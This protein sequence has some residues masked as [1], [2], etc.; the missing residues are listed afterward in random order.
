MIRD[1]HDD[2][3][4]FFECKVRASGGNRPIWFHLSLIKRGATFEEI[5]A[6]IPLWIGTPPTVEQLKQWYA[7]E[8]LR[9]RPAASGPSS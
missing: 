7:E 5:V 2:I 1:G 9:R 4:I 3:T 6:G 8:T